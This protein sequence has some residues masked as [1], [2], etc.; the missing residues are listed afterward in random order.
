[1]PPTVSLTD[2]QFTS[3]IVPEAQVAK[4][5]VWMAPVKQDLNVVD[6]TISEAVLCPACLRGVDRWP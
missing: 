1:M 3:E 5:L 2:L 6:C 4:V